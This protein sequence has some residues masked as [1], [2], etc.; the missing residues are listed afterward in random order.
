MH[1]ANKQ[2]QYLNCLKDCSSPSY[3]WSYWVTEERRHKCTHCEK[4]VLKQSN[5]ALYLGKTHIIALIVRD[6]PLKR[7]L[8]IHARAHSEEKLYQCTNCDHTEANSRSR[9][10]SAF[11]VGSDSEFEGSRSVHRKRCVDIRSNYPFC[12]RNSSKWIATDWVYI[13]HKT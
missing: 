9:Q 7:N 2:C 13:W 11:N 6:L 8:E 3:E 10:V 12:P 5:L 1:F 4:T